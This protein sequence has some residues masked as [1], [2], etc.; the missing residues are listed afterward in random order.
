MGALIIKVY[1]TDVL[2]H[3]LIVYMQ[4]IQSFKL[5][6]RNM[7]CFIQLQVAKKALFVLINLNFL[8]IFLSLISMTSR[9]FETAF[10]DVIHL[11]FFF[12]FL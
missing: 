3:F 4:T 5:F 1:K 10:L 12:F 6:M 2:M 11:F 7:C 8:F 9:V